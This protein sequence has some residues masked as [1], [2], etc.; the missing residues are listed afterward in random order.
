MI[1]IQRAIRIAAPAALTWEVLGNFAAPDLGAGIAKRITVEGDGVGAVRTMVLD[2]RIGA[3]YVCERL[4]SLDLA[5]RYMT[6]RMVDS[7]PVPFADYIGSIRVTP[8][9]PD[10]C[11]AVMTSQFVPVE[12]GEEVARQMSIANIETALANARRAVL[13]RLGPDGSRA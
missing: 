2:D 9:G 7:G 6:Y 12:I 4:E 5:D 3:G 10:A 13:A 11:V 1:R 8:A